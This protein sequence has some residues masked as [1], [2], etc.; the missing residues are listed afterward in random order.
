MLF[1]KKSGE[2]KLS[3]PKD[4]PESVKKYLI[5]QKKK[6]ASVVSD[7]KSVVKPDP[8]EDNKFN[9]KIYSETEAAVKEVIVK[10]YTT[11]DALPQLVYF[12][13]TYNK[14]TGQV[15]LV[16]KKELKPSLRSPSTAKLKSSPK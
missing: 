8:K 2:V 6:D 4:V 15:D 10:D 1:G 3:G 11:F 14:K 12:E 5:G 13:G 16:E 7:L 9:I